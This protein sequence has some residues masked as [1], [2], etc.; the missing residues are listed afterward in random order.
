[1]R[2]LKIFLFSLIV[3]ILYWSGTASGQSDEGGVDKADRKIEVEGDTITL[4]AGDTI[5]PITEGEGSGESDCEI[6]IYDDFKEVANTTYQYAKRQP[7]WEGKSNNPGLVREDE[8]GILVRNTL[9]LDDSMTA[10]YGGYGVANSKS[11]IGEGEYII[12]RSYSETGRWWSCGTSRY[13]IPE[14]E[15]VS[16]N[17]LFLQAIGEIQPEEPPVTADPDGVVKLVQAPT[18]FSIDPAYW[19]QRSNTVTAGR[20]TVTAT[21]DPTQSVWHSGE[22]EP[23]P[24]ICD[25]PGQA[26]VSGTDYNTYTCQHTYKWAPPP[27]QTYD[28]RTVAVF[29]VTGETNA[30]ETMGPYA[31]LEIE[32]TN[33]IEVGEVQA[34]VVAESK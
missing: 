33:P 23:P 12:E 14:G 2:N 27:G 3:V 10:L 18:I 32:T 8:N 20:V 24:I 31:D 17:A 6:E 16:V 11:Q 9:T 5:T 34:V 19:V 28:L 4:E 25:G 30:P 26:F 22:P 15:P 7:E 13:L 1:M 21:I 29:G